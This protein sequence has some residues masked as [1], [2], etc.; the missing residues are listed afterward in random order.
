[1]QNSVLPGTGP[2]FGRSMTRT[3]PRHDRVIHLKDLRSYATSRWLD[4]VLYLP[5]AENSRRRVWMNIPESTPTARIDD[6]R[7]EP[8]RICEGNPRWIDYG[9]ASVPLGFTQLRVS[10]MNVSERAASY[11]VVTAQSDLECNSLA[12]EDVERRLWGLARLD[13]GATRIAPSRVVVGWTGTLRVRYT[14][15]RVGLPAGARIRFAVPKAF[16]KPQTER[17]GMPGCVEVSQGDATI[18]SIETSTESH[19][20]WDVMCRLRRALAKEETVELS[21]T[22]DRTYIYPNRFHTTDR[23]CWHTNQPPLAAAVSVSEDAPFV[24]PAEVNGHDFELVPGPA[25]RLHLFLPGRRFATER[26]TLRGT[27]TDRYRN[28]PPQEPIDLNVDLYLLGT[29]E[30]IP[31]GTPAGRMVAGHR[32]EVPLPTLAPG[33]YRAAAFRAGTDEQ[34][35]RSNPLEVID[36][37]DGRERIYWGEIHGHTEMSDGCGEY[38]ALYRHAREEG[39]LDFAAAADHA[40]YHTDNDWLLMQ[41]ITNAWNQADRFVTLVGYEWIGAQCHRNV[42]TSRD[43]LDLFR[44]FYSPT[45]SIEVVWKHFRGD[46]EVVG[47]THAPLAHGLVWEHHDPSVER[48]VEVYSVWGASDDRRNTLVPQFA[49]DNPQGMTLKEIL[50]TGAKLGVTGGGDCHEGHV[51]FTCE[52]PD[53]QGTTPHTF[54]AV[55]FYRC[56]MTAALLPDLTRKSLLL[57]LRNRQTYATTGARILLDFSAGGLP[58]GAVGNASRVTCTCAVHG[59]S[60]VSTLEIVKD[61]AVVWSKECAGTDVSVEWEDPE[62]PNGEH[63]Y[64]HVTQADGQQAWSSPIW[65]AA[66]GTGS[67]T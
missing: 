23:P 37:D 4:M 26:L 15:G 51:G 21:Y 3:E 1:M 39:C 62:R 58:M 63:Y 11:L 2:T 64:L 8:K 61:G 56:G 50:D 27:F 40:C 48:F 36:E 42:Y 52:D 47:G 55:H 18:E 46:E 32:L 54:A 24:S 20:K 49:R 6:L 34:V 12:I 33:V 66:G 17:P 57:A 41:D 35:A 29:E 19:E 14:A 31:L 25:E 38:S 45:S 9:C 53:G 60:P 67:G 7:L 10:G 30:R 22:T 44:G 16:T 43:R 59:V 5:P 13:A 28:C 65:V